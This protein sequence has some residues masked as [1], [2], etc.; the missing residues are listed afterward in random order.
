[1]PFSFQCLPRLKAFS[2]I[3]QGQK[4]LMKAFESVAGIDKGRCFVTK[5]LEISS[6]SSL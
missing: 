5:E 2:R 1:M 3:D 6:V 4:T